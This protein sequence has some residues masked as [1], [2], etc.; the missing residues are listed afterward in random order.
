MEL[1]Q[2]QKIYLSRQMQL[3]IYY[4]HNL[5]NACGHGSI[6]AYD[7]G[8]KYSKLLILVRMELVILLPP[9]CLM[10]FQMLNKCTIW[11]TFSLLFISFFGSIC[12]SPEDRR[13]KA[14]VLSAAGEAI[15][16]HIC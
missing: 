6:Q 5:S 4:I 9:L 10:A 13:D 2:L 11:L 7:L 3:P 12:L 15:L 14:G 1:Y 8:R 16:E